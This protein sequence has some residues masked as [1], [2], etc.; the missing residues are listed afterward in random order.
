MSMHVNCMSIHSMVGPTIIP[1]VCP[2]FCP[3]V[4]PSIYPYIC[5]HIVKIAKYIEK[6]IGSQ[7]Y[8]SMETDVIH[9]MRKILK[10]K[11]HRKAALL[12]VRTCYNNFWVS[13]CL[14]ILS[15]AE[16]FDSWFQ[17][18]EENLYVRVVRASNAA[19]NVHAAW[20]M[21]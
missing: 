7:L 2:L 10:G 14:L 3:S 13:S 6:S 18:F 8:N 4:C 15:N 17:W 16:R 20:N 19:W 11:L 9:K 1:S 12:F 5:N 21:H